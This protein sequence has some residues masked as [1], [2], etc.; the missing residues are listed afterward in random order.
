VGLPV[1]LDHNDL[2]DNNAFAPR[3]GEEHLRFF[4]FGDAVVGDPLCSLMIPVN[5]FADQ[6]GTD[7][8][9][10]PRLRRMVDAYLEVWSDLADPTALRAAVD[11]ARQLARVNRS[12]TWRRA[13]RS[14]DSD[15]RAE[16]GSSATSWLTRLLDNPTFST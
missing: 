16:W 3:D 1:T 8:E 7:D 11:P 4:D 13:L 9:N 12:E 10:D 14:A 2:H 15:Q 6:L 5:V